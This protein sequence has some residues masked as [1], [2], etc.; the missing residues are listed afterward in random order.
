MRKRGSCAS[1]EGKHRCKEKRRKSEKKEDEMVEQEWSKGQGGG[2]G[3]REKRARARGQEA[4]EYG[5]WTRK[6]ETPSA[7]ITEVVVLGPPLF[8]ATGLPKKCH[9]TEFKEVPKSTPIKSVISPLT[10]SKS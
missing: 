3:E 10:E 1:S 4:K 9:W 6:N 8:P 2:E 7:E 5:K